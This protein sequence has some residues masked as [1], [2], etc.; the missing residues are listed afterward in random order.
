MKIIDLEKYKNDLL[1]ILNCWFETV[2]ESA[3]RSMTT[4]FHVTDDL[5]FTSSA[6]LILK[7]MC[8]RIGTT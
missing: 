2:P 8:A 3:V 7:Q 4:Y 5:E 1:F 6:W